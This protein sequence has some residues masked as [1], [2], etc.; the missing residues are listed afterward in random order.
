VTTGLKANWRD[1]DQTTALVSLAG[2]LD[3][4]GAGELEPPIADRLR[5]GSVIVDLT[6]V[7][8][9]DS[10]GLGVLYT[11]HRSARASERGFAVVRGSARAVMSVLELT[12]A[13]SQIPLFSSIDA[14]QASL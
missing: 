5:Q 9:I 3:L 6:D 13:S 12:K 10:A 11:A 14:A 8:F 7:D 1:L 2:E 4:A